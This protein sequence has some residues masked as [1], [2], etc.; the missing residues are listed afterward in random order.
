MA[1]EGLRTV[2][3]TRARSHWRTQR[4]FQAATGALKVV[5]YIGLVRERGYA[6]QHTV[7]I[8]TLYPRRPTMT[9][10]CRVLCGE[11]K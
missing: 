2:R 10:S 8:Y 1:P 9:W 4:V 11:G 3:G 7:R 5:A 6:D